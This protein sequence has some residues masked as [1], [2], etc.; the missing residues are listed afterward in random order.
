MPGGRFVSTN[1]PLSFLVARAF[2][3]MNGQIIGMPPEADGQHFDV[4]AKTAARLGT[5]PD[6]ETLARR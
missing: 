3:G 1:L 2:P 6:Q 4:N 5:N